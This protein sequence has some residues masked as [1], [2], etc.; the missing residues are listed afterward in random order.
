MIPNAIHCWFPSWVVRFFKK[1]LSSALR[2]QG[3]TTICT[4]ITVL[5][6]SCDGVRVTNPKLQQ[7]GVCWVFF[8]TGTT[9]PHLVWQNPLPKLG[10]ILAT[11]SRNAQRPLPINRDVLSGQSSEL[12]EVMWNDPRSPTKP[13]RRNPPPPNHVLSQW[14]MANNL[15]S[16]GLGQSAG[17]NSIFYH[18]VE[19]SDHA[20]TPES[21]RE[22]LG[23]TGTTL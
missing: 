8:K 18:W 5:N 7:Q 14:E 10:L 23:H 17:Q 2:A 12:P 11:K 21:S 16:L 9:P 13:C 4:V 15:M 19:N 20:E 1:Y 6:I 22:P 3:R